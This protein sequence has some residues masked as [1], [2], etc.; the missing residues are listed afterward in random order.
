MNLITRSMPK[1][2]KSKFFP[3]AERANPWGLVFIGGALS[4]DWLLEGYRH[5]IFPWP[6]IE[7]CNEVQW[8]S[9]DPRGIIELDDFHISRRLKTTLCGGRFVVTS[10]RDF[11]GV[12]DGCATAAGRIGKTWLTLDM[13]EAYTRMNA[14]GHAHSVE[15]WNGEQLVG[16]TY[17]VA[18]GGLFAAESMFYRQ[19]DASKVAL[20]YLVRHLNERSYRLLDIQQLTDH[21]ASLGAIEISRGE[22]LDRLSA[23]V[24]LPVTFGS[25]DQ[26]KVEFR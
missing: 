9:P 25:L 13:I 20:A 18:V 4:P 19:R 16:G 5:G 1:L 14:L 10:D 12:I 6:L 24:D 22:Y 7:G 3:P 15:V 23:A 21:T 17:G 8:W 11:V 26:S 2:R